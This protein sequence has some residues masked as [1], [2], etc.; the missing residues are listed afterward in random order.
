VRIRVKRK[1]PKPLLL[2]DVLYARHEAA[3]AVVAHALGLAVHR[4]SIREHEARGHRDDLGAYT[5]RE[6][7][8]PHQNALVAIAGRIQDWHDE[9][10]L[11][12]KL[13]LVLPANG[14]HNDDN[15]FM[16]WLDQEA[17][18]DKDR[19]AALVGPTMAEA[20]ALLNQHNAAWDRLWRALVVAGALDGPAI[21]GAIEASEEVAV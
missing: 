14:L 8:T 10:T 13:D 5:S 15:N 16:Y 21:L 9:E 17:G 3:H 11:N 2:F 12:V 6:P 1:G 4:V 19:G 7:G 18:G 20:T